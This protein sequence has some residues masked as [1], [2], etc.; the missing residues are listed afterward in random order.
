MKFSAM[1]IVVLGILSIA[2]LLSLLL[3]LPVLWLWNST[4]PELFGFKEITLW[5][6]WKISLLSSFLFRG[7]SVSSSK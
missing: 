6:A 7:F 4:L 1:V 3:A 2:F 5:T